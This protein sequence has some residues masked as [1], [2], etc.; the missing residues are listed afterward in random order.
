MDKLLALWSAPRSRSTAFFR[1]M[2]GRGDL[3]VVHEP[4]SYLAEFGQCAIDGEIVTSEPELIDALRRLSATG[5]VFFKDTTDARYPGALADQRFLARDG[6]HAFLIRHPVRTIAS[7]QALNP[8]V[9]PEQ[10]GFEAL[11]EL[12]E[13]VF[14]ATRSRP[15]V[16]D[17][18]DFAARPAETMK[19]FCVYAGLDCDLSALRWERGERTEWAP[20]ARWHRDASESTGVHSRTNDYGI[21]VAS[22]PVF[23]NHL[24]RNLPFYEKLREHALTG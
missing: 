15:L 12:Y 24:R 21:D 13:A 3:R 9:R 10:I 7:Y 17:G 22:H 18:D 16:L 20:S 1:A 6:V 2:A 23:G 19:A 5:P 4:F 14:T 11:Y 8:D